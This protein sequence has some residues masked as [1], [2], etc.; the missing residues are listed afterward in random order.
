MAFTVESTRSAIR[1]CREILVIENQP[2]SSD[3]ALMKEQRQ[4]F[5]NSL[6]SLLSL[7]D[8]HKTEIGALHILDLCNRLLGVARKPDTKQLIISF[9][10]SGLSRI[11]GNN[12][13]DLRIREC[14][15]VFNRLFSQLL[16]IGQ[17]N[18]QQD[19]PAL[20]SALSSCKQILTSGYISPELQH[21][22]A[23]M[24][25]HFILNSKADSVHAPEGDMI[26]I[27]DLYCSLL[28]KEPSNMT[29]FS[30]ICNESICI[31]LVIRVLVMARLHFSEE[32]LS[33]TLSM[34]MQRVF[35]SP[36]VSTHALLCL[37][38][39]LHDLKDARL[40]DLFGLL[41]DSLT[42]TITKG[43]GEATMNIE[44]SD[45][46]L[47]RP[48]EKLERRKENFDVLFAYL[49]SPDSVLREEIASY[50]L[51]SL[52][53]VINSS[54]MSESNTTVLVL[55]Y[56]ELLAQTDIYP[57]VFYTNG[58]YSWLV[59]R[60]ANLNFE[61]A[62][63]HPYWYE[64]SPLMG[65]D[66]TCFDCPH[67]KDILPLL[68][69]IV[70]IVAKALP[71]HML[72]QMIEA[73]S[74]DTFSQ[75]LLLGN[76]FTSNAYYADNEMLIKA[77]LTSFNT[78]IHCHPISPLVELANSIISTKISYP[79]NISTDNALL[80]IM[81]V[82]YKSSATHIHQHD[83]NIK[84][85]SAI[86][87]E[88]VSTALF[89]AF[90]LSTDALNLS[91]KSLLVIF[92]TSL[93]YAPISSSAL[94][95]GIRDTLISRW[96]KIVAMDGPIFTQTNLCL[97]VSFLTI[98][99]YY[100]RNADS[101]ILI[102]NTH[103]QE[104]P[105][106][107]TFQELPS[108]SYPQ[109][110]TEEGFNRYNDGENVAVL[111]S[112]GHAL[113]IDD[114]CRPGA[115]LSTEH[116][117]A[118]SCF[119]DS[120]AL[121]LP[122]LIRGLNDTSDGQTSATMVLVALHSIMCAQVK[123]ALQLFSLSQIPL[124]YK[125]A[126]RMD[127]YHDAMMP[128]GYKSND[129]RAEDRTYNFLLSLRMKASTLFVDENGKTRLQAADTDW[130]SLFKSGHDASRII[131]HN[132]FDAFFFR[133]QQAA[134]SEED[135]LLLIGGLS[136]AEALFELDAEYLR[137][138]KLI[139]CNTLHNLLFCG[140]IISPPHILYL[141]QYKTENPG[142]KASFTDMLSLVRS[143][144][145]Y[146][147]KIVTNLEK[148]KIIVRLIDVSISLFSQN[149]H[150]F[151]AA[152]P[153]M[154]VLDILSFFC[155]KHYNEKI[156]NTAHSII[157]TFITK[158]TPHNQKECPPEETIEGAAERLPIYD[159]GV[160]IEQGNIKQWAEAVLAAEELFEVYESLDVQA[161]NSSSGL[162]LQHYLNPS[163]WQAYSSAT[164]NAIETLGHGRDAQTF[165]EQK[166]SNLKK[167][168][169]CLYILI[170]RN[171]KQTL[172]EFI[173]NN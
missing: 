33:T 36:S 117:S 144:G 165:V 23:S 128:R 47:S 127:P 104:Y 133:A 40:V 121:I 66:C 53:A 70:R 50:I 139:I 94:I 51:D 7:I 97:Y 57:S 9:G 102:V 26:S 67:T 153:P 101:I 149:S 20:L 141:I 6:E 29:V 130:L 122:I 109:D 60:L 27:I 161:P 83:K 76:V 32:E 157:K 10:I 12:A 123:T 105:S 78:I 138:K 17:A 15:D 103:L 71:A 126:Y 38:E 114:W 34:V 120:L 134:V 72:S 52:L 91:I 168:R 80:L 54:E 19:C 154:Q 1:A 82:F 55:L 169:M 172:R 119:G 164:Q 39:L 111:T 81:C 22:A 59:E 18:K 86:A 140:S 89:E 158:Y 31:D 11:L 107:D 112:F 173:E 152:A 147:Q 4:R 56:L 41:I 88:Y 108:M 64:H 163:V 21:L 58:I 49:Q 35:S 124:P 30:T 8:V 148:N 65:S 43:L 146:N 85:C 136:F 96:N 2:A 84:E 150:D 132:C 170:D 162:L 143:E 116:L 167:Q 100:R 48:L 42:Q 98:I 37:S 151:T 106:L 25:E 129:P 44:T 61:E 5:H 90:H 28:N 159:N 92:T 95:E 13:P 135:R 77:L 145:P 131:L 68:A 118:L 155:C 99:E 156:I 63:T 113:L 125:L 73:T 14:A 93:H 110:L 16:A 24:L 115:K 160:S 79:D 171:I 46:I 166:H 62:L 74:A 87:I 45:K 3:K 75:V 142:F 69:N 137:S